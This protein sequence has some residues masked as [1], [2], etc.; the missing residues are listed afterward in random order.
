M[1]SRVYFIVVSL[2]IGLFLIIL[3]HVVNLTYPLEGTNP[4]TFYYSIFGVCL[5]IYIFSA[6]YIAFKK[7]DISEAV[8]VIISTL[9]LQLLPWIVRL[10]MG[11]EEPY[12]ILSAII[13]FVFLITYFSIFFGTDIL[14]EKTQKAD[15]LL[16]PK[17]IVVKDDSSY[18]DED[19]NF[20]G[21]G[22]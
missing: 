17:E 18:F 1:K 13:S 3:P 11:L 6:M 20:K 15:Q 9:I 21:V 8:I 14:T 10:L 22:K 4:N 2:L 12:Y 19:G 16:K 5:L 7:K